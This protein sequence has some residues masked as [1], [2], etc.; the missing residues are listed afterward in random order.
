MLL[1][2]Q[3]PKLEKIE[4]K[5]NPDRIKKELRNAIRILRYIGKAERR[6]SR[7]EG[8]VE[9]KFDSVQ[10]EYVV[11]IGAYYKNL[12]GHLGGHDFLFHHN[13]FEEIRK[14]IEELK[15]EHASLIQYN[16]MYEGLLKEELTKA[17]AE[18]QLLADLEGE[19]SSGRAEKIHT[20]L[21]G[22]INKVKGQVGD[23]EKWVV[24]LEATLKK[25]K[26]VAEELGVNENIIEFIQELENNKAGTKFLKYV[27]FEK[28][29]LFRKITK[30]QKETILEF[31]DVCDKLGKSFY[32]FNRTDFAIPNLTQRVT[33]LNEFEILLDFC[34]LM[35]KDKDRGYGKN[36]H[37]IDLESVLSALVRHDL[38]KKL[39]DVKVLITL[40]LWMEKHQL[41]AIR[42][43]S[44]EFSIAMIVRRTKDINNLLIILKYIKKLGV[45]R[46]G[47]FV[48]INACLEAGISFTKHNL[49]VMMQLFNQAFC[50]LSVGLRIK[51]YPETW[52]TRTKDYGFILMIFQKYENKRLDYITLMNELKA[53]WKKQEKELGYHDMINHPTI[54]LKFLELGRRSN[55]KEMLRILLEDVKK[56]GLPDTS[57]LKA[58]WEEIV[59]QKI[60][61]IHQKG[62]IIH[63]TKLRNFESVM[64][65][66]INRNITSF[67][68][69]ELYKIGLEVQI[70][71]SDDYLTMTL[72]QRRER[73]LRFVYWHDI[74]LV[75]NPE[76]RK[77]LKLEDGGRSVNDPN[78]V[79]EGNYIPFEF[80]RAIIIKHRG[81]KGEVAFRVTKM[82]ML[83]VTK[84]CPWKRVPIYSREGKLLW[85]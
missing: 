14:I 60:F 21:M 3:L 38:I 46:Q 74:M 22:L 47:V 6:T 25:A 31:L 39:S 2:G 76:K 80:I 16:S 69:A 48:F 70:T 71:P 40:A 72:E 18:T 4:G 17:E 62:L 10:K 45:T 68:S 5:E 82:T 28:I 78:D 13:I 55:K 36:L 66:G 85:P 24:A 59:K 33:N 43:N 50:K 12:S 19:H 84:D 15:V 54:H 8:K 35:L 9:E 57:E 63:G 20:S 77:F 75:V 1:A 81:K 73:G 44:P 23:V 53:Y 42:D 30:K 61:N 52:S 29:D 34:K 58:D 7:F 64:Y 79:I 49:K 83:R 65:F 51:L 26:K 37:F 32:A 41:I 67:Y 11:P 27:V 56:N